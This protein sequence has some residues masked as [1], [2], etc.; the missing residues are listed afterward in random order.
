L[1]TLKHPFN[2]LLKSGESN[3]TR[4]EWSVSIVERSRTM[5]LFIHG[6][7]KIKDSYVGSVTDEQTIRG[8]EQGR[9]D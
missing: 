7:I 8:H 9:I 2:L 1:N 4:V 3:M 5:S 6:Q